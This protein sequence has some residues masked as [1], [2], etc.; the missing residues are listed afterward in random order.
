M[1]VAFQRGRLAVLTLFAV[2]FLGALL[3]FVLTRSGIALLMTIFVGVQG[4]LLG[5]LA[6]V[7]RKRI[8]R[9]ADELRKELDK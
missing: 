5:W 8:L 6:L 4:A 3:A 7:E 9:A 2:L 1:A